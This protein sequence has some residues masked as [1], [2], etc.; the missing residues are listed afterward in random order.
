L[1]LATG[2]QRQLSGTS[3]SDHDVALQQLQAGDLSQIRFRVPG[4]APRMAEVKLLSAL[5]KFARGH[6]SGTYRT[7][8]FSPS[9][10]G[11]SDQDVRSHPRKVPRGIP[12]RAMD[13]RPLPIIQTLTI[14]HAVMPYSC[15]FFG[16]VLDER[17][18]LC[19][20][21]IFWGPAACPRTRAF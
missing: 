15:I 8:R 13:S 11:N 20:L 2:S 18:A 5:I 21:L 4:D 3:I 19:R 6:E 14:G 16:C 9:L 7:A 10:R 17:K 12:K 1:A